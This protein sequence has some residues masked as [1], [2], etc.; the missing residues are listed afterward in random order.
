MKQGQVDEAHRIALN[1]FDEWNDVTGYFEKHNGYY[2]EIQSVIE[3]A[4]T[5]GIEKA[6]EAMGGKKCQNV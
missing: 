2:Y 3:D 1:K 6:V 4:V 5:I